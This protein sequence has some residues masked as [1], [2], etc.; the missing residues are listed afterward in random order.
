MV[1]KEIQEQHPKGSD[2]WGQDD[3][4]SNDDSSVSSGGLIDVEPSANKSDIEIR[5]ARR[6]TEGDNNSI[7]IWRN[8]ILFMVSSAFVY[9]VRLSPS[10]KSLI[11][12]HCSLRSTSSKW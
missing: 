6:L 5:E 4:F 10:R 8:V 12:R 3:D 2:D 1:N 11:N 7:Q 9:S